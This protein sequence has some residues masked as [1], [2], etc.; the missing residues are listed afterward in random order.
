MN[1][2]AI[3]RDGVIKII[4]SCQECPFSVLKT[5]SSIRNRWSPFWVCGKYNFEIVDF[6][7]VDDNCK[8]GDLR[9]I[10]IKL[11]SR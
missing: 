7:I 4:K 10:K 9:D 8:L 11:I 3:R 6:S 5:T 1:S 2:R